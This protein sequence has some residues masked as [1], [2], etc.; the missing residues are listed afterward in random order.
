MSARPCFANA[1]GELYI[2][3]SLPT[4]FQRWIRLE[5]ERGSGLINKDTGSAVFARGTV[6]KYGRSIHAERT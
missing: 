4:P 3:S 2:Q 1:F 5:C 6:P